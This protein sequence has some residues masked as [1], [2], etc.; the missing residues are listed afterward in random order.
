MVAVIS[1]ANVPW[2]EK[3]N[4]LITNPPRNE[5]ATPMISSPSRL[6]VPNA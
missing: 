3:P 5:P 4:S 2:A 6:G 1:S